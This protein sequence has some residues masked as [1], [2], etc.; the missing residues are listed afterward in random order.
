MKKAWMPLTLTSGRRNWT[1]W[2]AEPENFLEIEPMPSY[3]A[4][5]V[6]EDFVETTPRALKA[7]LLMAL[8]KRKPFQHFNHEIDNSGDWRER[9]FA[10]RSEKYRAWVSG[11]L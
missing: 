9:W 10:F 7:R 5:Q 6:M 8:E 1:S 3:L 11:Q 2:P 4:F